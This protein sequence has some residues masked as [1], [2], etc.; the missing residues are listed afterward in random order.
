VYVIES[1]HSKCTR[2]LSSEGRLKVGEIVFHEFGHALPGRSFV[3][4]NSVMNLK[5]KRIHYYASNASS[6]KVLI[7]ELLKNGNR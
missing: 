1:L 7:D 2:T 4:A 6:R 3:D 5:T